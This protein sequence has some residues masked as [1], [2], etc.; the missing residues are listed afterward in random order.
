VFT[1]KALSPGAIPL[2]ATKL[3][4]EFD[5]LGDGLTGKNTKASPLK[6]SFYGKAYGDGYSISIQVKNGKVSIE[7]GGTSDIVFSNERIYNS[8]IN[9][10]TEAVKKFG[11]KFADFYI[12]KD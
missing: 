7:P 12:E 6:G 4:N 5:L 9:T 11:I 10:V 2:L 8:W 1:A 3:S